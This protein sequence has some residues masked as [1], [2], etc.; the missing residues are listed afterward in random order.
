MPCQVTD[1]EDLAVPASGAA[2]DGRVPGSRPAPR[3]SAPR[4]CAPGP[5][6]SSW[7]LGPR[8]LRTRTRLI[9]V[10]GLGPC[11]VSRRAASRDLRAVRRAR[12][13]AGPEAAPSGSLKPENGIVQAA[14]TTQG[15]ERK[16]DVSTQQVNIWA[17]PDSMNSHII[18]EP[19]QSYQPGSTG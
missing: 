16:I 14:N 10:G 8:K 11:R 18:F 2:A 7:C 4:D 17:K 6:S 13:P 9:Q 5:G 15:Q 19:S 3:R 12:G 1:I